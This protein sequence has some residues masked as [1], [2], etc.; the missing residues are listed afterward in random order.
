M[1]KNRTLVFPA[2]VFAISL[3]ISTAIPGVATSVESA[4]DLEQLKKMAA[5]FSPTPLKVDTS[6]LSAGDKKALVKLIEAAR[7]FDDIYMKQLWSGDLALK[8]E[9]EKDKSPLGIARLNYFRIN[10]SPWSEI[11]EFKSFVPAAP[12]RKPKTANF[13]PEDMSKEVFESWCN[14]LS[15]KEQ[16]NAKSFFTVIRWKDKSKKLLDVIPYSKFY[17]DDL[18]RVSTLLH[19]AAG[20]TDNKTL[21]TFLNSRA[22]ALLSNDYYKSDVAWMDLDAPLDITIGPYETYNDELFGYKAAFEAYVNLRNDKETAKLA[23]FSKHL[24][25]IEDNL[26]LDPKY[27]NPKLGSGAA[28]R[29]VD[30]ILVSG[31]GS[32]AVQTAAYNLPNDDLVVKQKGSKRVMLKNVQDAKFKK[33]LV[34]I[35]NRILSKSALEYVSFE[36]FFTHILAHEL[37][38]GLGPHEIKI[39]GKKSTPRDELKDL[40]SA[41]EE[42][43]AD[44]TGLFCLQYMMDHAKEMDLDGVLPHDEKAQKQ[45]YITYLASV[46]RTLRF[47]LAESHGKG[48]AVQMNFLCDKKAF[49]FKDDG[50]I[51]VDMS[52]I[53][54]AVSELDRKLLT[55]EAEGDY[56]GAKKL[57]NELGVIRPPLKKVLDRLK[58]IPNDIAP[59]FVTADELSGVSGQK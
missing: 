38:H 26:P 44:V 23:S 59:V 47:G 56:A 3:Q 2:L 4:P 17:V 33:V 50:T 43:K 16:E 14:R 41:V 21:K 24:Q 12:N 54:Q 27:R 40:Y 53:K 39:N 25:V 29:V 46:L 57:L 18:K 34:P 5:R 6:K 52:K 49:V 13:Y 55:L 42:A 8:K 30:E 11:D 7:I 45:L 31:D 32:H 58:D 35:A 20:L 36:M 19:E 10:K 1:E 22:D 9:L 51:E 48:T 15:P 37:M 28:I